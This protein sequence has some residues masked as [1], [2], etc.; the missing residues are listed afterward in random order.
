MKIMG[1]HKR[2]IAEGFIAGLIWC[3]RCALVA[4]PSDIVVNEIM[5]NPPDDA[6]GG[7]LEFVEL[8]NRGAEEVDISGWQLTDAIRFT[9]PT[10]T[11]IEADDYLVVCSDPIE[12]VSKYG[13]Y[14]V[15]GPFDGRLSNKGE[16]I[17]LSDDSDAPILIDEVEY[18]TGGE[19]PG[20]PDGDGPSLELVNPWVE[21]NIGGNWRASEPRV[22]RGTPGAP[23]SCYEENPPPVIMDVVRHPLSPTWTQTV[24]IT[25]TVIDDASVQTVHLNYVTGDDPNGE[26]SSL[27]MS[28]LGD[29][30]Y[31]TTIPHQ[32]DGTWV[33][34]TISAVDDSL[35]VGWWPVGAPE[36]KAWYLVDNVPAA[37]GEIVINEIMYHNT[38]KRGEDLEWVEILNA[39][40][41][42]IDLSKWCLKD[43][44]DSHAFYLPRG[45]ALAGGEFLVIC[46]DAGPTAAAYGIDNVVG[47]FGFR[48]SDG[49][50][51]VRLFNANGILMDVVEYGD[52]SPWPEEADGGGASLECVN[53]FGDNSLFSNWGPGLPAGSPGAVNNIYLPYNHDSDIVL[54]EIM[55]HP[56]DDNDGA[57]FIELFNRGSATVSLGGWQFTRGITHTFDPWVSVPAGGFLVVCNDASEAKRHYGFTA[58]AVTWD[59]GRLDHGGETLAL[60]SSAGTTIDIVKYND[61]PPWPVAADGFGSSLECINPFVDNN[62]PRNWRA[63][64]GASYW[65]FV[66]R[67]GEATS[68][69]LYIYMLEAGEC[70]IDDISITDAG[71]TYNYIPNGD[72]ETGEWGWEKTG[73]HSWSYR[74]T[75]QAHSGNACMRIFATDAGGSWGNSLNTLTDPDLVE[76]EEYVLSFWV[77]HVSGGTRLYSR[78]SEGGI[79]GQTVLAGSGLLS[80]PGKPNSVFSLDLPPFISGVEHVPSMPKPQEVGKIV[81]AVEDDVEVASVA[82]QY[83]SALEGSWTS[84]EMHDDGENGDAV[85]GDGLYTGVTAT[86]PSQ[87]IV[88]YVV[89]AWDNVGH[90]ARSPA[91]N[92]PKTNHAY[93]VY[94]QEVVSKLPVYFM[95]VPN[96]GSINP[97]SDNYHPATFVYDGKV[98]EH[99]GVRY[100]GQTSRAYKKKCLK[101]RFGDGD[102]FTGSFYNGLRSINLQAMWADKSYLREKL[103]NDMFKKLGVAYCETRHVLVYINGEYWGLFLEMEA[104]SRRFLK[105]NGRDDTGNLY[106]AYNTGTGTSGFEKKTNESDGSKADLASFL[107]GINNTPESQIE[108]FLN[109]RTDVESQITYNAVNSVINNSD[110][111]AKNYFLYHDPTSDEWEMFPWDLD[112]TYGRNYELGGGVCN[113]VIRWNNH[114]FFGT[115]AH[116]KND[117]PWN[118]VIDRFFYPENAAATEPFRSNMIEATRYVLDNFFTTQLQYREIDSLVDLI[119][120]EAARDRAKWGSY[121]SVDTDLRSQVSILKGFVSNRGSYLYSNF[122]TDRNA[123][124]RANNVYPRR[125]AVLTTAILQ[126][127]GYVDPNGDAHAASHWQVREDGEYWTETVLDTVE[128]AE[129]KLL[130]YEV[131]AENLEPLKLY[132]WRVRFEDSTGLWGN[133]SEETSFVIGFDTDSDGLCDSAETNTG[134]YISSKNAGTDPRNPDTDGDGLM[135]GEEVTQFRTDPTL[136]DSDGDGLSDG[137]EVKTYLTDPNSE[138]TDGDSLPDAW[139]VANLLDPTS[140]AGLNGSSGDPDEDGLTNLVEYNRGT[141]PNDADTDGDGMDDSWEVWYGLGPADATGENGPDGDPDG[142]GLCNLAEYRNHA[143]PRKDDT[144]GDGLGDLWEVE[145]DLDPSDARGIDGADGDPDG[146]GMI[147]LEEMIAGTDPK[148]DQSVFVVTSLKPNNPGIAISWRTAPGR[149][150]RVYTS[151]ELGAEWLS[152]GGEI[153]GTGEETTCVDEDAHSER[154]RYYRVLV[155]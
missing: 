79:G 148:S 149:I 23:N 69:R 104:P 131:P 65:Q 76:G 27:A 19:W 55:Y 138:D 107:Y 31:S 141:C 25:A 59:E 74:E 100:R 133:W 56:P 110:Q 118:R 75:G 124:K 62:H 139:E 140:A 9:F 22:S 24:T 78:L 16:R 36:S 58:E 115:R 135:D 39:T 63:S 127:S 137:E 121:S 150:Y 89:S 80:S 20:E 101:V 146:D 132:Y 26:A 73:N 70:L 87:T 41:H 85:A 35:A 34:Y 57:Q 66:Q 5:Y 152:L 30:C 61:Q 42:P 72:F 116:P 33:W 119:Q 48:L 64:S 91:Q 29:G 92:D 147:N 18:E 86:Y 8:Y 50:S 13:I 125:G 99:V 102:L 45:T 144:D 123:P 112:L 134:V 82:L 97:W 120:E 130:S 3:V 40:A 1:K 60:E 106:K 6:A 94:N 154:V 53:P 117:G 14:S 7:E 32:G 129:D 142:D 17:E 93:F 28:E 145:N 96:M 143:N 155:Q 21:N 4:S 54:N 113:D 114:I 43:D 81:A 37:D 95:S 44:E 122:L 151:D 49:G 11:I 51:L 47:D 2:R 108:D 84:V 90:G 136:L 105:R 67:T 52:S 128:E 111:P 126:A 77:K 83:K 103:A 71:G 98:H 15:I 10:G 46:H 153:V 68:S 88:Q 12:M 38:E 109:T